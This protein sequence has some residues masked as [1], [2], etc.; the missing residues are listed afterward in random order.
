MT[1]TLTVRLRGIWESRV[2]AIGMLM[3]L[4]PHLLHHLGILVGA[5]LIAGSRGTIL[6]AALG[7]AFSLPMLM[8]LRKRFN[9]WKA[10]AIALVFFA[11]MFALSTYFIGP[12][13]GHSSH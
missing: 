2:G 1:S 4:L 13:L 11:L 8:R 9:T 5:A 10:P 3:G 7:L 12:M 6:F